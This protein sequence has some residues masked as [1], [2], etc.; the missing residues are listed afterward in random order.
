MDGAKGVREEVGQDMDDTRDDR[1]KEAK[2]ENEG[3]KIH[4]VEDNA[5]DV[6]MDEGEGEEERA[7]SSEGYA[8]D[9]DEDGEDELDDEEFKDD[10][11]EDKVDHTGRGK[12]NQ[13]KD[14]DDKASQSGRGT[15]K[16]KGKEKSTKFSG[17]AMKAPDLPHPEPQLTKLTKSPT[18]KSVVAMVREAPSSEG[19]VVQLH[20]ANRDR[21]PVQYDFKVW[22]NTVSISKFNTCL[23]IPFPL[24]FHLGSSRTNS[25]GNRGQ[26][27]GT[28]LQGRSTTSP[29][30]RGAFSRVPTFRFDLL[31]D[32]RVRL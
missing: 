25:S 4:P 12:R 24:R 18:T 3:L 21:P 30:R 22:E 19:L 13:G 6:S 20:C 26:G 5:G 11:P 31:R 2:G 29:F 10:K 28:P 17:M 7:K 15:K 32:N 14:K 8:G 16:G 27:S 9:A 1:K 23:F